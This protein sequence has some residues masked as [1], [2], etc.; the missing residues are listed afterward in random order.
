MPEATPKIY[1][2]SY[3]LRPSTLGDGAGLRTVSTRGWQPYEA[4]VASRPIPRSP[5]LRLPCGVA[6]DPGVLVAG[7]RADR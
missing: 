1:A 7:T 3:S 4:S 2:F 6:S 5:A